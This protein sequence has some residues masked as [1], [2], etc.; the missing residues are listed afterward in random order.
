MCKDIEQL[1]RLHLRGLLLLYDPV[2]SW[3]LFYGQE[4]LPHFDI[5]QHNTTLRL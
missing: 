3:K 1:Q 5:G 4:Y 2:L